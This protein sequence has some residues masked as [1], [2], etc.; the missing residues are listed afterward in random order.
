MGT[1]PGSRPSPLKP[2]VAPPAPVSINERGRFRSRPHSSTVRKTT[3]NHQGLGPS[4]EEGVGTQ[5]VGGCAFPKPPGVLPCRAGVGTTQDVRGAARR[6]GT[7]VVLPP[8]PAGS[9]GCRTFSG[10]PGTPASVPVVS[11]PIL[12]RQEPR[13]QL[14][15]QPRP[16]GPRQ[17]RTLGAK[18]RP[19]AV[20]GR[21][22]ACTEDMS[23]GVVRPIPRRDSRPTFC[24]PPVLT[25]PQGLGRPRRERGTPRRSPRGCSPRP[26]VR[27]PSR[28][29]SH[30]SPQFVPSALLGCLGRAVGF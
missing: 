1:H 18:A 8:P 3:R 19:G 27:A 10:G 17:T 4:R 22:P 26:G 9:L 29:R 11:N 28:R 16:R 2:R 5:G 30:A 15:A 6:P 12:M 13:T 24:L 7:G 23:W 20:W 25:F 14:V 21:C